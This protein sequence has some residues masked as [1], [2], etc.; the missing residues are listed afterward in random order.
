MPLFVP[1]LDEV[2]SVLPPL[3]PSEFV[4]PFVVMAPEVVAPGMPVRADMAPPVA[5]PAAG[6]PEL[7]PV[8]LC[9]AKAGAPKR[10]NAAAKIIALFMSQFPN[11]TSDKV[12][13]EGP[14]F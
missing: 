13:S 11:F 8:G 9:C 7:W 14:D 3:S 5:P 4:E 10:V 1:V 12:P 6:P 2:P